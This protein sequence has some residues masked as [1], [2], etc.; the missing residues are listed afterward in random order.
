MS[1]GTR[2]ALAL[3][4]IALTPSGVVAK[5][6]TT[7]VTNNYGTPGGLVDMPTAQMAPDGQI[8]TTVS[9][10]DGNTKTMLSFQILPWISGSFRYSATDNLTPQFS[11]FYDR[12]F[13]L[14]FRLW[15]EGTYRPAV[16]LGLQDFIGTGILGAE[17]L[18]ASKSIGDR[19][20]VTGGLGWGRLGSFNSF[21]SIGNRKMFQPGDTGGDLRTGSWFRGDIAAFAGLSFDVTE[22]LTFAAEYSSDGYDQEVAA[23]I[24]DHK[25]PWNF[26]LNYQINRNISLGAFALHGSEVGAKLTLTLNPK[27]APAPGG[28]EDAPLPV[29]VRPRGTTADLNW[30]MEPETRAAVNRS[31]TETLGSSDLAVEGLSLDGRTAHLR[32]RNDRYDARAQALGRSLRGLSRTLPASV[33]TLHVTLVAAGMPSSTLTFSRSDLERL[34]NEPAEKALAVAQFSDPLS[35]ANL[36]APM[37]DVYPQF[38]WGIGP[39]LRTSFF[40]PD[41]PVRADVGVKFS[42]DYHVMPGLIASGEV[43]VKAFGNLDKINRTSNSTIPHVRSDVASYLATEEPT[44]DRLTLAKYSRLGH[45]LYGRATAGYLERMYAGIS[46]EVLWKPVNS[47]FALGVEANYVRPRDFDMLFGLRSRT[48]AGGVIPEFNGHVSAYYDVGYGFHTQ[49]DAGRYLAG[50]WGAT[51]SVDREFANGWKV[52][53]FVTRTDVSSEDFGEG[54]FD[55]GIRLSIPLSWMLGRPA[56]KMLNTTIRPLTRD[57]GQRLDVDGRLYE[58]IR[59]THRPDVAKSWGKFWR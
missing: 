39:Y 49:L 37:A 12:S 6:L 17:Y 32:L 41:N 33:E 26:G 55:K 46:G 42:G 57:G 7:T 15:K 59:D 18:V 27:N 8:S 16:A 54:S 25:S 9:H 1:F 56:Q 4:L 19:V 36:P 21:G 13:D 28:L 38:S 2:K 51:L 22:R 52:G 53:A 35:F 58:T 50:D 48:T 44:I 47:S 5:D 10:F 34:E 14:R 24:F 20:I 43:S 40:D 30:V 45:N 23:G 31:V 11:T 29:N 3:A